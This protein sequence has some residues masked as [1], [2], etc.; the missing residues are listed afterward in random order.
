MLLRSRTELALVLGLTGDFAQD[1]HSLVRAAQHSCD[2]AS[3]TYTVQRHVASTSS[4]A[5]LRFWSH[6]SPSSAQRGDFS[7]HD[8]FAIIHL[9][10]EQRGP[11]CPATRHTKH[12]ETKNPISSLHELLPAM[13]NCTLPPSRHRI[14]LEAAVSWRGEGVHA[15]RFR[16]AIPSRHFARPA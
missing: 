10:T 5:Q 12:A 11:S 13:G 8:Q 15:A 1:T 7:S 2:S 9:G 3:R 14:T 6:E 16:H 4:I